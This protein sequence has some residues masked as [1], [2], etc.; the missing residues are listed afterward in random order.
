MSGPG[1][2]VRDSSISDKGLIN[3]SWLTA[4]HAGRAESESLAEGRLFD[5][6]HAQLATSEDGTPLIY[7]SWILRQHIKMEVLLYLGLL[8]PEAMALQKEQAAAGGTAAGHTITTFQ[9]GPGYRLNMRVTLEPR[10]G[11]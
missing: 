11:K 8:E 1:T 6:R 2:T 3:P 4:T 10:S 7:P 5:P 9:A